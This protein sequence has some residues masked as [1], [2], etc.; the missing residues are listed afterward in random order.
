MHDSMT[1]KPN[2][3]LHV[4]A[5]VFAVLEDV[6]NLKYYFLAKVV[7]SPA[8]PELNIIWPIPLLNSVL[9]IDRALSDNYNCK[10]IIN[11]YME[12]KV[13]GQVTIY[14][15]NNIETKMKEAA[16]SG[17][18]SVS[19]WVAKIIEEKTV[20]EWPQDIVKLAGSWKDDFST[21]EELRLNS[22]QDNPR[23]A[24]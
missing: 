17:H 18:L 2:K 10:Y 12:G 8:A 5:G 24:I 11:R 20:T 22:S 16:K 13:M 6:V 9:T 15:D 14:L 19:K 4:T 3:T 23:E 21:I 7:V 1:A